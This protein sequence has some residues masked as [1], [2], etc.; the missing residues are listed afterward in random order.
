[1]NRTSNDAVWK[2]I[3]AA[4]TGAGVIVEVRALHRGDDG[5]LCAWIRAVF[6]T[7]TP[8]GQAAFTATLTAALAGGGYVFHRHIVKPIV[9]ELS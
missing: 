2:G 3:L 8:E 6:H 1:M 7:D 9:K 5:T 4:A